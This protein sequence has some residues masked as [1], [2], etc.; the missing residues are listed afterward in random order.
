[1]LLPC[2]GCLVPVCFLIIVVMTDEVLQPVAGVS[3]SPWCPGHSAAV[4]DGT[5]LHQFQWNFTCLQKDANHLLA[6]YICWYTAEIEQ[7]IAHG[8]QPFLFPGVR[9]EELTFMD[10]S[11]IFLLEK[12]GFSI[13]MAKS[14]V[15]PGQLS[16]L[17]RAQTQNTTQSTG[18]I[19]CCT[20]NTPQVPVLTDWETPTSQR[21]IQN[22][23]FIHD[24]FFYLH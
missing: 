1:M 21:F 10:W 19:K 17:N 2:A 15:L 16:H 9:Q 3:V 22:K 5:H 4:K 6:I 18:W 8:W 20:E 14:A 13:P 7:Q 24:V 23:Y 11:W 12:N